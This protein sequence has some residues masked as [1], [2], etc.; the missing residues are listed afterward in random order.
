M[1][2]QASI[3]PEQISPILAEML[4]MTNNDDPIQRIENMKS[5][6]NNGDKNKQKEKEKTTPGLQV[7]NPPAASVNN[8]GQGQGQVNNAPEPDNV[9]EPAQREA[10]LQPEHRSSKAIERLH[11]T[12]DSL[13]DKVNKMMESMNNMAG[14]MKKV[15]EKQDFLEASWADPEFDYT[16]DQTLGGFTYT[17]GD[18]SEEDS[19]VQ[20]EP[21]S[22]KLKQDGDGAAAS[23]SKSQATSSHVA[24]PKDPAVVLDDTDDFVEKEREP[25]LLGDMRQQFQV[26]EK[27]GKP[28]NSHLAKII[29]HILSSGCA[30]NGFDGL[31]YS[32]PANIEFLQKV[33]VN[34]TLWSTLSK[35][36]RIND[37]KYQN[38]HES[39]ILGM[40]PLIEVSNTCLNASLKKEPI[41][42]PGSLFKKLKDSVAVLA[43]ACHEIGLTRRRAL[44]PNVKEQY[45]SLCGQKPEITT[46]LF[47][48]NLPSIAKDLGE[49]S[50]LAHRIG[51][52]NRG[53]GFRGNRNF[54][55]GFGNRGRGA[56]QSD[57]LGQRQNPQQYQRGRAPTRRSG[58]RGGRRGAA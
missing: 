6:A 25:E 20:P 28:I 34:T 1:A 29:D 37:I 13:S 38:I 55:R 51:Y 30:Q 19:Y 5:T 58:F 21:P 36:A 43:D 7:K 4:K 44:K 41:E 32:R 42:N 26:E 24:P 56:P 3:S 17:R 53:G 57:F 11:D 9:Q 49:M 52:D 54:R 22:K 39:I 14:Q 8:G 40:L 47:G 15:K 45:R 12:F 18:E 16:Y 33:K 27:V 31:S 50:K 2:N 35:N 46:E 23:S 48:D 10:V